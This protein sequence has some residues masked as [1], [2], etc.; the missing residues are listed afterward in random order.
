MIERKF[1]KDK[2][3]QL[4]IHT[5]ISESLNNVG[6][7]K[8]ELVKT[9]L[10][11]KII[12]HAA[13]PGLVVGK[14]GE[15]IK[16]ITS[17]MRKKFQLDNP[18]IEI[19]EVSNQ[20]LDARI[21]AERIAST[22]QR[23]GSQRFKGT[24]HRVI[25]DVLNAGALG[26]EI[27]ISGKIPSARAKNWRFYKGY[28]KKCGDVAIEGVSHAVCKAEI[29]SGSIGIKVNI[30]PPDIELPDKLELIKEEPV[31]EVVTEEPVKNEVQGN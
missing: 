4:E 14:K 5:Y 20:M 7:A 24:V 29:K 21:V 26:I 13:R 28:L 25:Q 11:D 2:K 10:G 16:R 6:H 19:K 9:P 1:L 23:Y 18:E 8:T 31:K 27:L 15:N 17:A 3:K 12:I 22:L 30:M